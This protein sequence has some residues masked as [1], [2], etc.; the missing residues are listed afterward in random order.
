MFPFFLFLPRKCLSCLLLC[1]L[2]LP[3]S[4]FVF[5]F[6]PSYPQREHFSTV[7]CLGSSLHPA[8]VSDQAHILACHLL[9]LA[10]LCSSST[11]ERLQGAR[12]AITQR[13]RRPALGPKLTGVK[14]AKR[15]QAQIPA[16]VRRPGGL[17]KACL[18]A[19]EV[20][21]CHLWGDGRKR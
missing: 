8:S 15:T 1:Q 11:F 7:L 18:L 17:G 20:R 4:L 9:N 10:K 14:A 6:K 2:Q 21:K 12:A 3:L 19:R 5:D 13:A 16:Q